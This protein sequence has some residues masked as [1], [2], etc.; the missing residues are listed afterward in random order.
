MLACPAGATADDPGSYGGPA[1]R[2]CGAAAGRFITVGATRVSCGIARRVA[3]GV[4]RD[5]KRFRRWRC[6]GARKGSAYGHCHGKG[7]R[8]GAIVHWGLND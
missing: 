4:V 7:T 3:T 6:P 5:G 8:R 2:L 1:D